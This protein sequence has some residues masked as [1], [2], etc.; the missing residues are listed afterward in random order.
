MYDFIKV[1]INDL[2]IPKLLSNERLDFNGKFSYSTGELDPVQI[3]EYKG[4]KIAVHPS[5]TVLLSGSVHKFYNEGVHNSSLYT[6]SNYADTLVRLQDEL[7]VDPSKCVVHNLEVGVN[8]RDLSVKTSTILD[9]CIFTKRKRFK[10]P[11]IVGGNFRTVNWNQYSL[12]AYDKGLQYGLKED[13]FRWELKYIKAQRINNGVH[14]TLSDLLNPDV[15]KNLG[16][17]LIDSWEKVTLV[18]SRLLYTLPKLE[19]SKVLEWSRPSYWERLTRTSNGS[20]KNRLYRELER[21]KYM[22]GQHSSL[23]DE[24]KDAI[25]NQVG[26]FY[27]HSIR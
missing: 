27:T 25:T 23:Q 21:C 6:F 8:L 4:L 18:D 24:I 7:D 19:R 20:V 22:V 12:K 11:D 2:S 26:T 14:Y 17:Q 9:S 1:S 3:A 10:D 13:V 16:G 5:G 15:C